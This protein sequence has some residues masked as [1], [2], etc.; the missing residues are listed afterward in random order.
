MCMSRWQS[1]IDDFPSMNKIPRWVKYSP[2]VQVQFHAFYIRLSKTDIVSTHLVAAKFKQA[3]IKT[4]S[5]P[6]L[7]LSGAVL[8]SDLVDAVISHLLIESYTLY[9]WLEST[10]ELSWLRK[11]P[12]N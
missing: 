11:P 3:P 6:I 9:F 5:L 12:C 4:V 8:V 1:F 2:Y 7:E 10:I